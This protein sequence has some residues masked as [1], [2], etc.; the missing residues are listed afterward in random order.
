MGNGLSARPE[1]RFALAAGIA[2]GLAAALISVK[3][4]FASATSTAAIAML[5]VPFIAA[6]AMVGAGIWGLAL[7]CVWQALR[8]TQRYFRAVLLSAWVL[9]LA[10]PAAIGWALWN[11]FAL[12]RA[13][14]GARAMNAAE[15]DLAFT[16]SPWRD[17]RY[18]LGAIA[19]N[20]AAD[21]T[22]L[23]RIAQ[24]ADPELYQPMGTIWDVMGENAKGLAVMRLLCYHPNIGAAT[25][26]RLAT[27]PQSDT[28]LPDVLRNPK[29]PLRVLERYADSTDYLLEWG[30]SVNPNTPPAVLERLSK[31]A[32]LTSR[33]NLTLNPATPQAT[34]M[35]LANDPDEAVARNARAAL[36]RRAQ[37][38]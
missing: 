30:L 21:E 17:N 26:E 8:G 16:H 4:I 34:L 33:L 25:L 11:G 1:A 5:F 37:G 29:T 10:G 12:E 15:L 22:L 13:V 28:V 14:A 27:G 2:G 35:R 38:G 3:A 9:A 31:S 23:E 24:L 7:G 19:Q 32:N 18:F 36:T 6:A 20:K